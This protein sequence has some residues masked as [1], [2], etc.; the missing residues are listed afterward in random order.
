M[1]SVTDTDISGKGLA[2]WVESTMK[3][4]KSMGVHMRET[5][6]PPKSTARVTL[7]I[8]C[9]LYPVADVFLPEKRRIHID[10]D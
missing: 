4:C 2:G 9:I 8:Y 7:C 1:Q 3:A 10:R 5:N 6:W